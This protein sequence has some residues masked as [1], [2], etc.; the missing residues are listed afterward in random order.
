MVTV[1]V[2]LL[3]EKTV[4]RAKTYATYLKRL[5]ISRMNNYNLVTSC[6]A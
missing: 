5:Q 6:Y 1:R 3:T 2:F 4:Q